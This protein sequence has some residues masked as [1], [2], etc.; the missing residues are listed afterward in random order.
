MVRQLIWLLSSGE[1][2]EIGSSAD[3]WALGLILYEMLMGHHPYEDV[4]SLRALASSVTEPKPVPMPTSEGHITFDLLNLLENCLTKSATDRPTAKEVYQELNRQTTTGKQDELTGISPFRGLSTFEEEHSQLYFGREAEVD[5][6][7]E[8]LRHEPILPVIGPSGAGKSSFV[9]AGVIPRLREKGPLVLI[10]TRPGRDPFLSLASSLISAWRQSGFSTGSLGPM[11]NISGLQKVVVDSTVSI[12]KPKDLA[13]E[14]F[15]RPHQLGLLLNQLA[16]RRRT[17]IVLF[18]DQLEELCATD[19]KKELLPQHSESTQ[20]ELGEGV[21]GRFMQAIAGAADDPQM[22]VRV[23]LTLREEFLTRLMT[24]KRVREALDRIMVL[25]KP[26]QR[27]LVTIIERTVKAVGYKFEEFHLPHELVDDVS[28]VQACLPLLQFACQVMW[29]NRDEQRKILTRKSYRDMDGV[30]GALV[31]HAEGVLTGLTTKEVS[32]AKK[33]L[34]RLVTEDKTRRIMSQQE[35]LL[36]LQIEAQGVLERL[37]ESRLVTISRKTE[38]EEGECELVHEA[39]VSNWKRLNDWIDENREEL[40]L[41]RQL[42]QAAQLWDKRGRRIDELWGL[43]ALKEVEALKEDDFG[44]DQLVKKFRR[45][46]KRH[47]RRRGIRQITIVGI[48]IIVSVASA[49]AAVQFYQGEMCAGA[50]EKIG[51]VWN[52]EVKEDI[53]KAFLGSGVSYSKDTADR[54]GRLFGVY[55]KKWAGQYTEACEATHVRGEQSDEVL[56]LRMSCL[57]R[58]LG[59]LDA[60][61]K[62]FTI[63]DA[64]V[65]EK[66]VQASTSLSSIDACAD[67]K[68]L[69]ASY[70]PPKTKEAKNKVAKIREKLAEVEALYK[71]GK[72]RDGLELAKKLEKEVAAVDYRPIQAELLYHLG[73]LLYSTGEY[74]TA[75]HALYEAARAAGLSRDGRLVGN[76]LSLLVFVV[77]YAQGRPEDG[78]LIGRHAEIDIE[79]CGG[80]DTLRSRFFNN[81][82]SVF[83]RNSDYHNALEYYQKSLAIYKKLVGSED[84]VLAMSLNNVGSTFNL[85]GDQQKALEYHN[86]ALAIRQKVLGSQHPDVAQSLYNI[87]GVHATNGDYKE[88]L[89]Y[90]R[91]ALAIREKVLAPGHPLVASVLDGIGDVLRNQSQ[92]QKALEYYRRALTIKEKAIGP[93]H[94]EVGKSLS[95]IGRVFLDQGMLQQALEPL[96]KVVRLCQNKPCDPKM[97]GRSLFG[98][99][100]ALMAQN[101]DKGRVIKLAKQAREIFG[102]TPKA[103]QERTRRSQHL[104]TETRSIETSKKG[105]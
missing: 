96:G 104:A 61:I 74:K 12:G 13:T 65:I 26:S 81:L 73:M 94:P 63:A 105:P 33:I 29:Q 103:I 86:R 30:T 23:I 19:Q 57:H 15:Q 91:R 66:S 72:Y 14:M 25:R 41:L 67:E 56:D 22:P 100:R 80:D 42:E 32:F 17:H 79:L 54:I 21:L 7:V 8:K 58:R 28:T 40:G 89:E 38:N 88:S 98:L 37:V 82:G 68:A 85:Q 34:L 59:E 16:G 1:A 83:Y 46:S 47:I 36:G 78:L 20:Q 44:A 55:T 84:L 48:I 101:K 69:R 64:G 71:T 92:Y 97:Y 99:A 11:G 93:E 6:F 52:Q 9:K 45:A 87:G 53:N 50:T 27:T 4:S 77:G 102:K 39:L 5:S 2:E 51:S 49:L 3:I 60:L 62:V 43:R 70:P 18:V 35:L 10:Q 95:G 75:E 31:Q 90:L 76:I 24:S